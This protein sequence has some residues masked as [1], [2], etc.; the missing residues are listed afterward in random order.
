MD[1]G[2]ARSL[3][4]NEAAVRAVEEAYDSAGTSGWVR[5]LSV[6]A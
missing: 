2:V 6:T 3:A 1:A 4:A 5:S